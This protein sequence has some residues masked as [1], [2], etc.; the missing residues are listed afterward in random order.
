MEK[1]DVYSNACG[2]M[3]YRYMI[4]RLGLTGNGRLWV[5]VLI[6]RHLWEKGPNSV[7]RAKSGTKHVIL[8]DGKGIPPS[9]SIDGVNIH[10]TKMTKCYFKR[11]C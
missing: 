5:L 8:I 2:L 4:K 6:Q 11:S 10:S 1:D 9:M 3:V 7:D